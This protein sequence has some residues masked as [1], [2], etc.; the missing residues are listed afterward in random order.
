MEEKAKF[1]CVWQNGVQSIFEIRIS[2]LYAG[3]LAYDSSMI[4]FG[5][6]SLAHQL[7]GLKSPHVYGMVGLDAVKYDEKA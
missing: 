2:R 7:L 4:D 6:S 3:K 5:G 1:V